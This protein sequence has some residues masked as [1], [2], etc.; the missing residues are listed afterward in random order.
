MGPRLSK[1]AGF[2]L[3]K[4]GASLFSHVQ[5]YHVPETK[6]NVMST[7][8]LMTHKKVAQ[9]TLNA[10]GKAE[11]LT[12]A[13]GWFY[14]GS[15][16]PFTLENVEHG[17]K[18]VK[19]ATSDGTAPAPVARAPK[20]AAPKIEGAPADAPAPRPAPVGPRVSHPV[21][22]YRIG[23]KSDDHEVVGWLKANREWPRKELNEHCHS[24]LGPYC[25]GPIED[26]RPSVVR[27]T[28]AMDKQ[29]RKDGTAGSPY[30]SENIASGVESDDSV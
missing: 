10:S 26:Y 15:A 20:A 21:Y 6:G 30:G 14:E 11:T 12:L 19:S 22:V 8:G 18:I 4:I 23:L 2:S 28:P 16:G 27:W 25:Q 17:H 24:S 1:G 5:A 29:A 7:K 13:P 9:V 3:R